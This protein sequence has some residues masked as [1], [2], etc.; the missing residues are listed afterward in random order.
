M[1]FVRR[2]PPSPSPN[3]RRRRRRAC[4]TTPFN[5]ENQGEAAKKWKQ[6]RPI[7]SLLDK[8]G[9]QWLAKNAARKSGP[10]LGLNLLPIPQP[11]PVPY[12]TAHA[13]A[14]DVASSAFA[15]SA[16]EKDVNPFPPCLQRAP[17]FGLIGSPGRNVIQ[18]R[19]KV[20]SFC[21]PLLESS[22]DKFK[23]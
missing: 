21:P 3:P 6:Y 11:S 5:R 22:T 19:Q 18:G 2:P 8:N 7:K 20:D 1:A 4:E 9:R 15:A 12:L 16:A 14:R 13:R 17:C 10:S 23:R